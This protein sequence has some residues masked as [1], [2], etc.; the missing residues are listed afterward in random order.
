MLAHAMLTALNLPNVTLLLL[1][2]VLG[3][4]FVLARF[5]WFYD[6][7]RPAQPWFNEARRG[8]LAWK[9]YH[10]GYGTHPLISACIACIE[11]SGG[12]AV[13]VGLLTV[14]ALLGLLGVLVCATLCTAKEKVCEQQPVD[15]IDC[16]SCYL[17]C[18]EGIY[19]VIAL[20][21]LMSGPGAL[22]MDWLLWG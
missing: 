6:P 1:R 13:I 15:R 14:P 8:H 3:V 12:V 22:S 5:R 10:C 17:W 20:A 19:L 21:L 16:V 18:V 7:S 4:F 9:L 11:V 2:L